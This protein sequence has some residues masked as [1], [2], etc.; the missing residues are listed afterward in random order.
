LDAFVEIVHSRG[1][2][3]GRIGI[4]MDGMPPERRAALRERLPQAALLDCSN[5]FR[6]IRAVKSAEEL[7]RLRRAAEISELAVLSSLPHIFAGNPVSGLIESYRTRVA[8]GDA[9]FD[10]FAYAPRGLGIATEPNHVLQPG[11]TMY[12]DFG[13]I[14]RQY[15]SDTGLTLTMGEPSSDL[16]ARYA[17]LREVIGAGMEQLRPGVKGSAVH[18]AMHEALGAHVSNPQGHSLGLEVREYPILAMPNGKRL[19]DDCID[20]D[21]DL[22]LETDMVV[23]LEASFFR[24][25]L[26]SL[27]LEQSWRITETGCEPLARQARDLPFQA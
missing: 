1:L 3:R 27:N 15:F 4:E 9:Q 6:L 23:N 25:G 12:I 11:D 14:Y 19:R 18:R 22:P 21:A 26:D 7:K 8:E 24:P 2:E 16:L 5:L 13:C 10:H 20:L 17:S